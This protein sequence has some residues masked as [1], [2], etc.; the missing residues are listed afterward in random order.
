MENDGRFKRKYPLPKTGDVFGELYV[1]GVE[2]KNGRSVIHCKCACGGITKTEF[3]N[4]RLGRSTRCNS[5]AKKKSHQTQTIWVEYLGSKMSATE[6][7]KK[8]AYNF[9]QS[10][11]VADKLKSGVAPEQIVFESEHRS[12]R[13]YGLRGKK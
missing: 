10:H 4:L 5:C 13:R 6:F 3:T 11:T 1:L 8:Y 12:I 9:A 7:H 2:R